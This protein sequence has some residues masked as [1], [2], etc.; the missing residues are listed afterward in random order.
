[1]DEFQKHILERLTEVEEGLHELRQVTW[2]VCQGLLDRDGPY[3]NK[4]QKW[5]FFRFLERSEALSLLRLKERF[6]GR[7]P[8]VVDAELRWILVEEPRDLEAEG[9]SG[10]RPISHF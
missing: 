4:K 3:S 7:S 10:H 2:P 8:T 9:A 5:I 1:M 6:M